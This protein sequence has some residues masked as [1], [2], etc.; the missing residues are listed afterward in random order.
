MGPLVPDIISANLNYIAA[1]LIG[2]LFGMILEQAGFSS[3]KKL[4]GLFY[5]YDFTVLRVFF[6]AGVTAMLGVIALEH[7]GLLDLSLVYVNPTFIWSAM[8][9]GLIMGLGFVL[10]GFCPGT[11]VCAAAIGKLDAM[12]FIIGAF[13]GVLLF[14][15]TYPAWEHLYKAGSWGSPRIFETLGISQSLFAFLLAAVALLAF[16]AVSIIENKVNGV[17]EAPVRFTPYYL[18]LAS[19]GLLMAV[20]S[21]AFTPRK[22][23][24]LKT[25]EA[26]G[27]AEAYKLDMMTPDEFAY[28]LMNDR[29]DKLRIMDFRTETAHAGLDLPKSTAFTPDN[30]FEKE[31]AKALLLRGKINVFAAEDELTE[32]K[33]AIV[34]Q[35]LGYRRIKI[36]QG[37][38]KEFR[39]QILNF[40]PGKTASGPAMEDTYRFREKARRELPALLKNSK[41]AG[42]AVHKAKRVLGGC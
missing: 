11:S 35:K 8:A 31:P 41:P 23:S 20:S 15:E 28:R 32:R 19:A 29:E 9:G 7:F 6:T 37:G 38:L 18:A 30:L 2:V 10:G 33:M 13:L 21:F 39:E 42:P 16:W 40:K 36:L 27:F 5:G 25:A 24:M 34:A 12:V 1:L 26:P 3:T 14:A 4:V 22:E 17:K